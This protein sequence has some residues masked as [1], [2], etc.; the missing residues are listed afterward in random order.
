MMSRDLGG[1]QQS[2]VDYSDALAL[3]GDEVIN[4]SSIGA[5]INSRHAR[6]YSL[7]NLAPWCVFSKLYLKILTIL[8]KPDII[9]CHGNRA[10]SF[11]SEFRFGIFDKNIPIVGVAHNYSYKHLKKCDYVIA[12]TE[13]LQEHLVARG[14]ASKQILRIPNMARVG[15]E[16]KQKEF[17]SPAAGSPEAGL[18]V[19]IGSFGRFV[20]KKGFVYLI[21]AINILKQNGHDVRL[22]LGGSGQDREMLKEKVQELK[23]EGEVSIEGWVTDKDAFFQ[24]MDI[25]CLPSVVEPF[26]IILLEAME[27]SKPIIATKSGGPEEVIRDNVDGLLARVES[28]E[29]LAR[30]IE[31]LIMDQDLAHRLARSGYLRLKE[32][33][34]INIVA[35]NLSNSLN[36]LIKK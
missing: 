8:L 1:I 6:K 28:S 16:Y 34:D 15:R 23:L 10:I 7:P 36:R 33:Y 3:C 5:K 24:Q 12:L 29:D 27:H 2:F 26:G 30:K 31:Q 18:P 20:A 19:V 21:E 11:A 9:I 17:S 14:I 22:V 25:F 35:K 32:N 4:I 13:N